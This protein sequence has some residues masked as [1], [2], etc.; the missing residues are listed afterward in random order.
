MRGKYGQVSGPVQGSG[1]GKESGMRRAALAVAAVLTCGAAAMAAE[2]TTRPATAPATRPATQPAV[3]RDVPG[4]LQWT[5]VQ[6][7]RLTDSFGARPLVVPSRRV[8]HVFAWAKPRSATSSRQVDAAAVARRVVPEAHPAALRAACVHWVDEPTDRIVTATVDVGA[9]DGFRGGVFSVRQLLE[10]VEVEAK[11]GAAV[12]FESASSVAGAGIEAPQA[13]QAVAEA[14]GEVLAQICLSERLKDRVRR[15]AVG[16]TT[17]PA[18][19]ASAVITLSVMLGLNILPLRPEFVI[20]IG[21]MTIGNSMNS[22]SLAL[23]RLLSEVRGHRR[24][25]EARML[26]GAY[27]GTAL[28]PHV[29]S[30]VRSALIPTIDSLKTLGIVFIPGGMTGMLMG[31]VE[32]VFAAQYQLVIYFMIFC[33]GTISTTVCTALAAKQLTAGGVSLIELPEADE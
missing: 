4:W 14:L 16:P 19:Q 1:C 12:R 6:A 30:A 10:L 28:Q 21:G 11:E 9:L 20:P 32:P 8:V 17:E 13:P 3:V 24:K 31:G 29:R 33:G 18:T 26:L 22:A 27:A 2:A 25:I 7:S 5:S 15:L 23:N